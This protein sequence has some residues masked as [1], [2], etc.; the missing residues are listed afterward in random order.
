MNAR[1]LVAGSIIVTIILSI[2]SSNVSIQYILGIIEP[3]TAPYDDKFVPAMTEIASLIPRNETLVVSGS[4]GVIT[5]F[6]DLPVKTPRNI[7]SQESLVEWMSKHNFN[8]LLVT[9]TK[10]PTLKALFNKEG[11]ESTEHFQKIIGF[12]TK[13]DEV[14]L[15]KRIVN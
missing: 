13:F 7:T 15:F 14:H 3:Q 4:G 12:K 9:R 1:W 8:F 10:Y 5:F 11:L 2:I 6:T